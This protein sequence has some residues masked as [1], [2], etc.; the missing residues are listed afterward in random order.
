MAVF[1]E[2]AERGSFAA[3]AGEFHP[4]LRLPERLPLARTD[5]WSRMPGCYQLKSALAWHDLHKATGDTDY[6][7][8]YE[9]TQTKTMSGAFSQLLEAAKSADA[10]QPRRR[11]PI[12]VY[13]DSIEV[14]SN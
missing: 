12:S 6:L 14:E 9:A 8:W 11:D 1:A 7:N 10:P 4:I 2:V 13:L 5:Q 3:A